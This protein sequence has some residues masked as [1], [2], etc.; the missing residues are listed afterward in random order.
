MDNTRLPDTLDYATPID[1][2]VPFPLQR[3]TVVTFLLLAVA[4]FMVVSIFTPFGPNFGLPIGYYRKLNRI[5]SRVDKLPGV[6]VVGVRVNYDITLEDFSID[7]LVHGQHRDSLYFPDRPTQQLV[8]IIQNWR[9]N[10]LP[11]YPK[12]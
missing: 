11:K 1:R 9:T 4:I 6:T 2:P 10:V 12:P 7:V 3:K 8:L 5:R